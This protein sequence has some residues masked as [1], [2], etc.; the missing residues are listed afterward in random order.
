MVG[1]WCAGWA[2]RCAHRRGVGEAP[3]AGSPK[4]DEV[5]DVIFRPLGIG[6]LRFSTPDHQHSLMLGER[7]DDEQVE[8][9]F[10]TALACARACGNTDTS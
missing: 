4:Q 3:S 1:R 7:A 6:S 9:S 5:S 2:R 8:H 10:Q